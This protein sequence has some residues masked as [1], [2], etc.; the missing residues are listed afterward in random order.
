MCARTSNYENENEKSLFTL[1]PVY[2]DTG[3]ETTSVCVCKQSKQVQNPLYLNHFKEVV[4][5][6]V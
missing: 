2:T 5:K 6:P 1:S 4:C 3:L